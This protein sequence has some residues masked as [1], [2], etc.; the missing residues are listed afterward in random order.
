M[1]ICVS[2]AVRRQGEEKPVACCARVSSAGISDVT[3]W[4]RSYS[5]GHDNWPKVPVS[6]LAHEVLDWLRGLALC[7]L[8]RAEHRQAG[9]M[10]PRQGW[11]GLSALSA[12]LLGG[13]CLFMVLFALLAHRRTIKPLAILLTVVSAAVTYF[14]TKVQRRHRQLDDPEHD[15][16]RLDG[17][18]TAAVA[19]DD[20]VRDLPDGRSRRHHL[21]G[22]DISFAPSGRYL[23]ASLGLA[24]ISLCVALASLYSQYNAIHRAGN[25]SN[26]YIVY[27][28][29]PINVI[30]STDQRCFQ[31]HQEPRAIEREGRRD[32]RESLIAGQP[33]GGTRDWRVVQKEELQHLRV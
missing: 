13:L 16:Y 29:V 24:S 6:N 7:D 2:C 10:V 26:K 23:L 11:A 15:S 22:I 20:P 33:G 21:A 19:S 17:G 25:V 18:R 9:E 32:I 14:I 8:Q 31:V 12:F 5:S 27:S 3:R 30:A 1:R 4:V 28:L